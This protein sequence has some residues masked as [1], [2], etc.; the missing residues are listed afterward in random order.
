[1]RASQIQDRRRDSEG[2]GSGYQVAQDVL[3]LG[4]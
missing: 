1:M 3:P 4:R 2:M